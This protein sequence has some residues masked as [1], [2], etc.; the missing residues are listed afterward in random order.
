L[1]SKLQLLCSLFLFSLFFSKQILASSCFYAGWPSTLDQRK[2]CRPPWFGSVD[3]VSARNRYSCEDGSIRCNPGL[4]G[5]N[6]CI[7]SSSIIRFNDSNLECLQKAPNIV[8]RYH[9]DASFRQQN[10][11]ALG[12][13]I[14]TYCRQNRGSL[15]CQT[16]T[17]NDEDLS[18]MNPETH[19]CFSGQVRSRSW[20]DSLTNS[21]GQVAAALGLVGIGALAL[22]QSGGS[23]DETEEST[24]DEDI[25]SQRQSPHGASRLRDFFS[26]ARS[27]ENLRELPEGFSEARGGASARARGENAESIEGG[28]FLN[29]LR[30]YPQECGYA[31]NNWNSERLQQLD[32]AIE[33]ATSGGEIPCHPSDCATAS[34]LALI[35]RLQGTPHFESLDFQ[36]SGQLYRRFVTEANSV[37]RTFASPPTGLGLGEFRAITP[38]QIDSQQGEGWPQE[39]DFVLLNRSNRT[40][41]MTVFSHFEGSG[42]NRQICYW[43]SNRGTNGMGMQCEQMSRMSSIHVGRVQ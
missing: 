29:R 10:I 1:M 14:A 19:I 20:L 2:Q 35:E 22:S 42:S 17:Q 41:H 32:Q 12:L 6:V 18:M 30:E 8:A 26:S 37:E 13:S 15:A 5:G 28:E 25:D 31:F 21:M 36:R 16:N 43:S 23:G 24:T 4:F 38:N 3:N 11:E 27:P 9:T 39:G 7:G 40:G 33:S 34:Y